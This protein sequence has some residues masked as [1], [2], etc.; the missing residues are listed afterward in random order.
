MSIFDKPSFLSGP[1][2][3]TGD[4]VPVIVV[5][6]G[7]KGKLKAEFRFTGKVIR[8]IITREYLDELR[9]DDFYAVRIGY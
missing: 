9:E 8:K 7:K 6:Y 5:P 4:P 2:A 3:P 1:P